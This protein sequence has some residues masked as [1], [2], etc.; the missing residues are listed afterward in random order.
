MKNKLWKQWMIS[1]VLVSV[2][3]VSCGV[4]VSVQA[5][6]TTETEEAAETDSSAE[7]EDDLQI[8]FDQAVE[9]AMIAE[10]GEILPV[11]SLDEG[12]PYA[13]Y[14]EEGRVLLYTFHKYPDSYLDGTDVKLEWG[15]VW[16]F[17]GG[18][19]EDWYQENKEGVTDWQT[20]MKE[21]LGLTPDNESNYVTAM[22]VKPEDVFR[23]AYISDIGTVEMTDSF[24]EDV[25]AD[26][27]AWFDAN[28]IS[29]YYDGEY[30]WTRLGYTY[31]WADNG[32]AYGLSEFI[33]KQDSDVKVAYTVELD[34]MI[35]KLEDNTWNPEAE[36]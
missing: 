3:V 24:S 12:E 30:P 4:S 1:G 9:D 29:S 36:N 17:T 8:L 33:V 6:E 31:D 18:E 34:E 7:S 10:D 22:W 20:R 2:M 26:Y 16:T 14:N 19:L 13:V 15:N 35:Q 28:I 25:D 32:Q 5:E 21:L 27:K 11:V 23:P